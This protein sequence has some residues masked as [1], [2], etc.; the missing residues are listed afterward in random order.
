MI[1]S[2]VACGENFAYL[3]SG[4]ITVGST[5]AGVYIGPLWQAACTASYDA[6]TAECGDDGGAVDVTT[7]APATFA[8]DMY[9]TT[10]SVAGLCTD[11]SDITCY[12]Y[13]CDGQCNPGGAVPT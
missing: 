5:A 2:D 12:S 11:D 9:V 3:C 1:V 13:T 7:T 6:I 4:V 8:V 10:D